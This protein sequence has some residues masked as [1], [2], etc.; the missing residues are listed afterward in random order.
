MNKDFFKRHQMEWILS[1]ECQRVGNG[2]YKKSINWI[3]VIFERYGA[4]VDSSVFNKMWD[5]KM[6]RLYYRDLGSAIKLME[7]YNKL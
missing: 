2:R 4:Y 3:D 7:E 1:N 5:E 6:T